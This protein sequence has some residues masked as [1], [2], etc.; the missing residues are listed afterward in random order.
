MLTQQEDPQ[1]DE[2]DNKGAIQELKIKRKYANNDDLIEEMDEDDYDSENED[3]EE[4][5]EEEKEG[6]QEKGAM[7]TYPAKPTSTAPV[8]VPS[9]DLKIEVNVP[10]PEVE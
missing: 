7:S 2:K 4:E 6:E 3:A 9:F 8:N 1:F 5:V 10:T